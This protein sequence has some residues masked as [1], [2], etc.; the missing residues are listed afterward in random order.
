MRRYLQFVESMEVE[1]MEIKTFTD[2]TK[3]G[4]DRQVNQFEKEH[5]VKFTQTHYSAYGDTGVAIEKF[6]YVVF[7]EVK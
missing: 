3:E 5:K 6:V 1:T 2:N 4:I 7:Y